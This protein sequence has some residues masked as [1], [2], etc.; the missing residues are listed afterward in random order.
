MTGSSLEQLS[1]ALNIPGRMGVCVLI[2]S[3][4]LPKSTPRIVVRLAEACQ[5][6]DTIDRLPND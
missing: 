1:Q 4:V 5:R 3:E 2:N 6:L